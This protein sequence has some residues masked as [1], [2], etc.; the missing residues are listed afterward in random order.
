MQGDVEQAREK[1]LILALGQY[2]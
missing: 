2:L 1:S